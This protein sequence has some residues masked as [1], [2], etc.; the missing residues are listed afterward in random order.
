VGGGA[1]VLPAGSR[2]RRPPLPRA[3]LQLLRGLPGQLP[4]AILNGV[5]PGERPAGEAAGAQQ[6]VISE[7]AGPAGAT[8]WAL[9]R[10]RTH[11][12]MRPLTERGGAALAASHSL[13]KRA[14]S[15]LTTRCLSTSM[16]PAACALCAA[17]GAAAEAGASLTT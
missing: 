13:E 6:G 10:G 15:A 11:L 1:G 8:S 9:V 17:P 14:C 16:P 3:H 4:Q 5:L 7:G 2:R 12:Y